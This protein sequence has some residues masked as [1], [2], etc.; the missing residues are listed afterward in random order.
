MLWSRQLGPPNRVCPVGFLGEHRWVHGVRPEKCCV[1][2]FSGILPPRSQMRRERSPS[3]WRLRA[4]G[5]MM[6]MAA[7]SWWSGIWSASRK[8]GLLTCRPPSECEGPAERGVGVGDRRV[9]RTLSSLFAPRGVDAA[10]AK[11]RR[12]TFRLVATCA[13]GTWGGTLGVHSDRSDM[14]KETQPL[15]RGTGSDSSGSTCM[16]VVVARDCLGDVHG[17]CRGGVEENQ[18][19]LAAVWTVAVVGSGGVGIRSAG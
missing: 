9:T 18:P 16:G 12:R 6:A 14:R 8:V 7:G 4:P 19:S 15:A 11:E 1:D 3:R 10:G 5:C 13:F 2:G 17:H